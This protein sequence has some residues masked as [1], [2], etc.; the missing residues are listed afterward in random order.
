MEHKKHRPLRT[1]PPLLVSA[2]YALEYFPRPLRSLLRKMQLFPAKYRRVLMGI[3]TGKIARFLCLNPRVTFALNSYLEVFSRC[4]HV[5]SRF[6]A[7]L[8]G[9][10]TGDEKKEWMCERAPSRAPSQII[11]DSATYRS[12]I[13]YQERP[14]MDAA[15]AFESEAKFALRNNTDGGRFFLTFERHTHTRQQCGVSGIQ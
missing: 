4:V 5:L 14:E 6:Q 7:E 12:R 13:L 1:K 2:C 10:G 15:D 8:R 9:K 3:T 11:Q